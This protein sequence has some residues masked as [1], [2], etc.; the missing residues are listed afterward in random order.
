MSLILSEKYFVAKFK[1]KLSKLQGTTSQ[2]FDK[3]GEFVGGTVIIGGSCVVI[4]VLLLPLLLQPTVGG[5]SQR[6]AEK[7]ISSK[8]KNAST[9]GSVE[10]MN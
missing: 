1:V 8:I 5:E 7:Y 4:T 2:M 10:A 9:P 6:N 3:D